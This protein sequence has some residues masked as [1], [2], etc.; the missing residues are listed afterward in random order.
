MN[1]FGNKVFLG[2]KLSKMYI[3]EYDP[4]EKALGNKKIIIPHC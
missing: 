3:Y 1:I 4:K 2:T